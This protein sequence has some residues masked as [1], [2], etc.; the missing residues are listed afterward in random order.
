M[1]DEALLEYTGVPL[2]ARYSHD[3]LTIATNDIE[4]KNDNNYCHDKY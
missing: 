3:R 1:E 4:N 2:H